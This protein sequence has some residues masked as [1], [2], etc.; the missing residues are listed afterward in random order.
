MRTA[1]LILSDWCTP[2]RRQ[3]ADSR[4]Q[5]TAGEQDRPGGG[6]GESTGSRRRRAAS[7]RVLSARTVGGGRAATT[8]ETAT[9]HRKLAGEDCGS[10]QAA[11]TGD[12]VTAA[13]R[14]CAA[15]YTRSAGSGAAGRCVGPRDGR[16][17]EV[18]RLT[19]HQR[20]AGRGWETR[21]RQTGPP[22][23]GLERQCL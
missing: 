1:S 3:S 22:R 2:V 12:R 15:F 14:S 5:L 21:A 18:R 4:H 23:T 9:R 19:V 17:A 7:A 10:A 20:G 13:R 11:T 8:M 16:T 6:G